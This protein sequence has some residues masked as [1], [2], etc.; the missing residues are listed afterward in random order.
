MG[1]T[2]RVRA[3]DT[4]VIHLVNQL[5]GNPCTFDGSSGPEAPLTISL[6]ESL[7]KITAFFVDGW[8]VFRCCILIQPCR[9]YHAQYFFK[10]GVQ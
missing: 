1:P 5:G 6:A 7:L 9:C 2:L 4:L 10:H 3:G 8:C